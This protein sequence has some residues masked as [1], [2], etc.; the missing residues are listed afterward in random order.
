MAS[1]I[2]TNIIIRYL[3]GDHEKLSAEAKMLFTQIEQ[4]ELEVIILDSVVMEA[5]FVLHK[6]YQ[7]P[8][9]EVLDDLK[10]I[11][12]FQGVI[13]DDKFQIIEALNIVLYKNLDFVDALLCVKSKYYDLELL[14]FDQKLHKRCDPEQ[15]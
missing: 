14:S 5:F 3:L 6:F 10:T 12:S 8:K 7:L 4:A 11:L 13:N 1:L 2:D 9:T 15:S